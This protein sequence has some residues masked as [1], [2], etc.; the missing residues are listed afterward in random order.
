[1]QSTVI[2]IDLLHYIHLSTRHIFKKVFLSIFKTVI[3][4]KLIKKITYYKRKV[5]IFLK[6]SSDIS[7]KLSMQI[8]YASPKSI[9][10]GLITK[11]NVQ[12]YYFT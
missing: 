2:R 7:Y 12:C 3:L 1:M 6:Y 5:L 11:N 10:L 8:I 9:L 4:N